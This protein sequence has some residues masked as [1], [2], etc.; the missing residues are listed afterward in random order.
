M[1]SDYRFSDRSARNL[2]GVHPDLV[3]VIARGLALSDVD[4]G[5]T[6]GLRSIE[7]QRTLRAS[8][9]SQTLRSRHLTGHAVDVMAYVGSE[10]R[11]DWPLYE[12]I[13]EAVKAASA[14]MG[15]PVEWGGDWTSLRDGPHYQLPWDR[16]PA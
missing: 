4:F 2:A 5:V 1:M 12:R 10:G 16:Y 3:A 11:W 8:G 9:A 6:E 13:A 14:E 15:I 7:R